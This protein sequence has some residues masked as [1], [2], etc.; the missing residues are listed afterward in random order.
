ML[1][2]KNV[3]LF[4]SLRSKYQRET[5]TKHSPDN[6][7]S[8]RSSHETKPELRVSL[9]S[10]ISWFWNI[11]RLCCSPLPGVLVGGGLVDVAENN[12]SKLRLWYF[13]QEEAIMLM[14][15]TIFTHHILASDQTLLTAEKINSQILSFLWSNITTWPSPPLHQ[16]QSVLNLWTKIF[17]N[18]EGKFTNP[19]PIIWLIFALIC[20]EGNTLF[21]TVW[22]SS[23]RYL[24]IPTE[25]LW[26]QSFT[27]KV[28]A[29]F[30][31]TVYK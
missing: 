2:M 29:A 12:N 18:S 11:L 7:W 28:G 5:I 24:C 27:T 1:N 15:W 6:H 21:M 20:L 30:A 4:V 8:L 23:F 26:R 16:S 13:N 31:F 3:M 22:W 10:D 14:I 25:L 17:W 9:Q 19:P